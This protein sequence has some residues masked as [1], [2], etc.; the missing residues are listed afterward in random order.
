MRLRLG[1]PIALLLAATVPSTANATSVPETTSTHIALR[2][3]PLDRSAATREVHADTPFDLVGLTWHGA[4]PEH[5]EVRTRNAAG[6]GQWTPLEPI[7]ATQASEPLWTGRTSDAQVRATRGSSDVTGELELVAINPG[8]GPSA[9]PQSRIAGQPPIVSR[10][11]WAA[12]EKLMTW[13]PERTETKAVT[14]H[15]TA[16][17][18]DYS[19]DQSAGIVRAIYHYH[20]VELKWGDIGYH[21]L[22]DKCG[23]IFEGRA[24]GLDD[25]VIGGHARG[26]NRNTF[27]VA[28]LGNYDGVAPSKSTVES[29]AKI[30]AWK[31]DTADVSADGRTTLIAEPADNANF[32]P[33]TEVKLPTIFGHRDVS[34][35]ACPGQRGYDQL[36]AIRSRATTLQRD[37]QP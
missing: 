5:I 27:G 33:G 22:V 19:C 16:E 31:L 29:V 1:F 11:Q 6:W 24:G 34:K 13:P 18:N 21:A 10:A 36:S 3:A 2:D 4:A 15:H 35:T 30:S 14:V 37:A 9:V 12:D 25:D 23:T 26:F 28:M 7:D 17:S 8:D 20:A 32:P